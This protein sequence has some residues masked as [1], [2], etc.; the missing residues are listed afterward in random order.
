MW[1]IQGYKMFFG[2]GV[3]WIIVLEIQGYKGSFPCMVDVGP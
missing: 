1:E 3:I 2:R